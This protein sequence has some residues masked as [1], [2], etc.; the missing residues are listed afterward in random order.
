MTTVTQIARACGVSQ[1][2]V[3]RILGRG[4]AA[5]HHS[6]AT[7]RRVLEAARR[8]G[9]RPNAAARA[10]ER[11]RFGALALLIGTRSYL[12]D[13]PQALLGGVADAAESA[14]LTLSVVRLTDAQLDGQAPL[15]RLLREV[16]T[17]GLLVDFTH[18]VPERLEKLIDRYRIPTVWLNIK[19]PCDCVR[20]DDWN[21][22]HRAGQWLLER[23]HRR[24]AWAQMSYDV[25]DRDP[26]YSVRDRADGLAA[27]LQSAGGQLQRIE[28]RDDGDFEPAH[29]VSRWV[30]RLRHPD[31]P[32]AIVCYDAGLALRIHLAAWQAGLSVPQD[33]SLMT[34]GESASDL[35]G[36][37]MTTLLVPQRR[38]GAVAV[39]MI[40]QRLDAPGLPLPERRLAFDFEPGA[41]V[42]PVH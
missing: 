41:T 1:P 8:L 35:T 9:Y 22:G 25:K 20:P 31:R 30:E 11:G 39:D 21:A 26:H 29:A 3:S 27:A 4:P 28:R 12:S 24:I 14:D 34:F 40:R 33:L 37:P 16:S 17:D 15:P 5:H 6:P 2:T 38:M 36:L 42:A 32:T 13:L 23:G 7:R 18:R 19:R 10:I